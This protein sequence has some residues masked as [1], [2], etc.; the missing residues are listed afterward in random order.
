[1]YDVFLITLGHWV[2]FSVVGWSVCVHDY[3][4]TTW[5]IL[6]RLD[7]RMGNGEWAKEEPIKFVADQNKRAEPGQDRV[8][9]FFP[10]FSFQ[11][12]FRNRDIYCYC[13]QQAICACRAATNQHNNWRI[14]LKYAGVWLFSV[15]TLLSSVLCTLSS[16]ILLSAQKTLVCLG[17]WT[18]HIP[19]KIQIELARDR[20]A[21][22]R[23]KPEL[24]MPVCFQYWL[25]LII[26]SCQYHNRKQC[27]H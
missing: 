9:V 27:S 16:P 1:M 17:K 11:Q 26:L 15:L 8:L 7:G 14:K 19:V 25:P 2:V 23:G 4:K 21:L 22:Q 5:W 20:R 10:P 18:S 24:Q 12:I 6:M 3:T 13:R